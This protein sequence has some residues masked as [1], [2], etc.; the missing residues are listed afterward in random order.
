MISADVGD[1][2]LCRHRRVSG[3]KLAL[4]VGHPSRAVGGKVRI[5]LWR[6]VSRKWTQPRLIDVDELEPLFESDHKKYAPSIKRAAQAALD[7]KLVA[8]TW[9]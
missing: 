7:L 4:V 5:R 2:M 1:G 3:F 6:A 9:S 8:R